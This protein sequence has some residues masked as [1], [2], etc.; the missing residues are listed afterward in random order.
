MP[1]IIID[2]PSG[3]AGAYHIPM[4]VYDYIEELRIEISHYISQKE[5]VSHDKTG[6][7]P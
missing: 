1:Y 4:E 2:D 7:Q 3:Y 6:V 5:E